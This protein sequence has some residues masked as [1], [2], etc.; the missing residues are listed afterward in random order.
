[1]VRIEEESILIEQE[2]N[3]KDLCIELTDE[4]IE[5]I[6]QAAKLEAADRM[7]V[8]YVEK[9]PEEE[10]KRIRKLI[11]SPE[12]YDSLVYLTAEKQ[13]ALLAQTAVLVIKAALAEAAML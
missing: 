2:Q 8:E 6:L 9:L 5:E 12:Q 1:M 10:Q 7:L 3:G 13:A 4:E 11:A